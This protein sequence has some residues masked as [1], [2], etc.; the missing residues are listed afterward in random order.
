MVKRSHFRAITPKNVP[1]QAKELRIIHLAEIVSLRRA[2]QRD[3]EP[4]DEG[5]KE[6]GRLGRLRG[7]TARTAERGAGSEQAAM[8]RLR[9][10]QTI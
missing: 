3:I 9:A 1:C 7:A 2:E 5:L 10:E 8:S 4:E 6:A